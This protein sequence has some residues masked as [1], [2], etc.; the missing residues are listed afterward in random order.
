MPVTHVLVDRATDEREFCQKTDDD[1]DS[2]DD[3]DHRREHEELPEA[4]RALM[5]ACV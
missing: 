3:G 1:A 5:R 4:V 2:K